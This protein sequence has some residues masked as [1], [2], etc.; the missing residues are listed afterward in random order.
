MPKVKKYPQSP[1]RPAMDLIWK[2][3]REQGI[4]EVAER[5]GVSREW[6]YRKRREPGTVRLRDLGRMQEALGVPKDEL[7]NALPW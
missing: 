6:M 3:V 4:D 2:Y 5:L 7:R 1:Y